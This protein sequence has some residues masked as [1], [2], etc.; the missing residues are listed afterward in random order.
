M[1]ERVEAGSYRRALDAD[2]EEGRFC[3]SLSAHGIETFGIEPTK[4]L[5]ETACQRDPL[6][7]Y[8]VAQTKDLPLEAD[9]FD[10]VVFYLTLIDIGDF[11]TAFA[12]MARVLEPGG[13]RT[14]KASLP[15]AHFLRRAR[16][17]LRLRGKASAVSVCSLVHDYGVAESDLVLLCTSLRG[18]NQHDNPGRSSGRSKRHSRHR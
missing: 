7:C 12:E 18:V 8:E 17:T 2:C 11:P 3:R 13:V 14:S 1:L 9:S 15:E 16:S 5:I 4:A 6:G 10:L